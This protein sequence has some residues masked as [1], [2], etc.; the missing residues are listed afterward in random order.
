[1]TT[2]IEVTTYEAN[3]PAELLTPIEAVTATFMGKVAKVRLIE[4]V[5]ISFYDWILPGSTSV[6]IGVVS[7]TL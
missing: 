2:C 5:V 7:I 1:M 4:V 3:V 6:F